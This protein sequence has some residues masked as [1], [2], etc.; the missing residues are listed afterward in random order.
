M[1][2]K[3]LRL[4]IIAILLIG[5]IATASGLGVTP[6]RKIIDFSSN[7]EKELSFK[8]INS[9]DRP[10]NLKVVIKG[11]LNSSFSINQNLISINAKEEKDI[12]YRLTMPAELSPGKH[13]QEI[14]LLE[15]SNSGNGGVIGATVGVITQVYVQAPYP[16]KYAEIEFG[17]ESAEIEQEVS[18]FLPITNLGQ[19]N[20]DEASAEIE[21]FNSNGE[22]VAVVLTD[23]SGIKTG[24]KKEIIG[25]WKADVS[26]GL[27]DAKATITYDGK[28]V[29]LE[30]QFSIGQ[31]VLELMGVNV[32]SFSLGEIA[33]F[34]MSIQSKWGEELKNVYSQTNVYNNRETIADFK[35]PTYDIPPLSNSTFFSYWDTE[36]VN[37]G[38][39]DASVY[40][41]YGEKFSKKNLQFK[42]NSNS[43]ETIG[44]GYAI[45]GDNTDSKYST[46]NILIVVIII[47][48][49][50]NLLW[51]VIFRRKMNE[52]NNKN[53]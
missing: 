22:K 39:Y 17:I 42:V 51:F 43:I 24:E 28:I 45:Y 1:K 26:P 16:G 11:D 7:Q 10:L 33:K 49:I 34:E 37:K 25:K 50:L 32:K 12:S 3:L 48:V 18:F 23:K 21:V 14:M 52:K 15:V 8:V 36:G 20:I 53:K 35:S 27:Y 4:F 41:R 46:T 30:K 9:E 13:I 2:I 5:I 47:L 31:K 29:N 40:L 38:I 6:G 44:L 19:E